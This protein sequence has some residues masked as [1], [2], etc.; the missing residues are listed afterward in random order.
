MMLYL[1]DV[2]TY[3]FFQTSP[4]TPPSVAGISHGDQLELEVALRHAALHLQQKQCLGTTWYHHP[5]RRNSRICTANVWDG[6]VFKGLLLKHCWNPAWD[7]E[8]SI[9][10]GMKHVSQCSERF[11]AHDDFT[12]VVHVLVLFKTTN[13][14]SKRGWFASFQ[15]TLEQYRHLKFTWCQ[16]SPFLPSAFSTAFCH[17]VKGCQR[18]DKPPGETAWM[19]AMLYGKTKSNM[20][21][22]EVSSYEFVKHGS[23]FVDRCIHVWNKRRRFMGE[24]TGAASINKFKTNT[25]KQ[26]TDKE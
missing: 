11:M 9:Q 6:P 4:L 10:V 24:S 14:H 1:A 25:Q 17:S 5:S 23:W 13:P 16:F 12:L 7:W 3:V 20:L 18:G 26:L 8:F 19:Q 15:N 22:P 21:L 2:K